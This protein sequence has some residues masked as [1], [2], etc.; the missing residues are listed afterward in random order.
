MMTKM[1]PKV[2]QRRSLDDLEVN[3]RRRPTDCTAYTP[4]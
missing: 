4:R 1:M 2:K 3:M